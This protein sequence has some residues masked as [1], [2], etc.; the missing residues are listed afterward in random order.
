M[1][2][3]TPA[4]PYTGPAGG[5]ASLKAS[6]EHLLRGGAPVAGA[7]A[8]LS[9]NQPEGFDCP[10]CAW[11]DPK[12]TSSF[13]FCESG[14]KAVAWE[15]TGKRCTPEV[16]AR[17]TVSSLMAEDEHVLESLGR[18][19]HPMVYDAAEDIYKPIAWDDAFA[20]I[21]R[22][23]GALDHP[24][25]AIFYTSGRTSNEA[26]FLWQLF[27][28]E[29]GTNNLPDC[30]NM[31]HE[32]SGVA[33]KE[34][35]GIGKGT[36]LLE[37][38]K[39]AD[40]IFIFGQN[41]GTNHPR[42]LGDLKEAAARGAQIVTVNPLKERGLERFADPKNPLA[43]AGDALGGQGAPLTSLY[44]QIQIGGDL[45]LV[46][47]MMKALIALDE[48]AKARHA[49]SVLDD[50]FIAAH[51]R[52]LGNL[53]ADLKAEPWDRIEAQAGVSRA[54]IEAAA[55]IYAKAERVICTW[56]MGLTQH[57]L[58]V[59]TI[60]QI[61]N[62]LLLR[63]NIG[64]PGTGPCPVRGHSNVQGD[65]TMGIT[66]LP[67]PEFL[68]SLERV[69]G[70]QAPRKS[71]VN[72][73]EAIAAM[74]DGKAKVLLAMGGNFAAA[75]PDSSVTWP[76]L[77]GLNLTVHVSTKL[78]RSHLVHGKKALILPALGRTE[79]DV[80]KT[81]RQAVT[82]EDSMSMVHASQGMNR[83][84]SEHLR[85]EPW[86]VAGIAQATLPASKV[87]WAE[88][89]EDYRL[90]RAKIEAVF[91]DFENFNERIGRA[92]GFFLGNAAKDRVWNTATAKANFMVQ[93][94]PSITMREAAQSLTAERVFTLMTFRAHDQYNTTV[95]ARDDRYRGIKGQR[96]V[97]FI[98]PEDLAAI[99]LAAGEVVDIATVWH[100]ARER[101][102]RG[103]A[104]TP[105]D[106]PRGCLGAYFPET[107]V[108]VP[109]DSHGP[110][111]GTPTNKSIPVVLRKSPS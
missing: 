20:L 109:L 12:H 57:K 107:N 50:E 2:E 55:A 94:L 82:V 64:R 87:P 25:Q 26:A 92:G 40:A 29:F 16:M 7:K 56:A 49:K 90:I 67:R 66:E 91:S 3:H 62:L 43:M 102:A 70:F 76:A 69:F 96:R 33:L 34:S 10:G 47:G 44:L 108:L 24:D 99:G 42:M 5:W 65:R 100:D 89:R 74:R 51:T 21:G 95:Y 79:I 104:L 30:S 37:D 18:L 59:E 97:V 111:S 83:P 60:Q 28:R 75:C 13:E 31:C 48:D 1:T 101:V 86:I 93:P 35:I 78:N 27:V 45:A 58:G 81:G 15:A 68:D 54:Q 6:A 103:F 85:S 71:G 11:G 41:P 19:T 88:L 36:I 110:R 14:V 8:L 80:Q 23:L 106:I 53:I 84:A 72:T 63:G 4:K 32:A 52:G 22:E 17:H 46:K 61:T 73:V 105:Y 39:L 98:H 38:M 9:V 77:R